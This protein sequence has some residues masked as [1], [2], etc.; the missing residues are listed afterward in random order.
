VSEGAPSKY[1]MWIEQVVD[2]EGQPTGES[3]YHVVN[4]VRVRLRDLIKTGEFL[5][6]VLSEAGANNAGRDSG[7]LRH[8]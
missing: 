7:R 8:R 3:R 1:G 5:Q 4:Q 6:K 2:R